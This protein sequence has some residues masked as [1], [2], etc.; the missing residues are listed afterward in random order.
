MSNNVPATQDGAPKHKDRMDA[1]IQAVQS[2]SDQLVILLDQSGITFERFVEVFRRALINDPSLV[3]ADAASVVQACINACTDGLLPDKRQ[4]AIV[5]YNVNVAE[6][7]KPKRYIKQAQWQPMYQGLLDLAYRSGLYRSIE[8]RVVYEGDHFEYELGDQPFIKHRPKPRPAGVKAPA[9]VAS[10]AVAVLTNGGV[11]REVFEGADIAKVNA[12]SRAASGPG[13][14]WPEEMA[15]KGPLRRMWKFIPK[16]AAM[17]RVVERDVDLPDA[18]PFEAEEP[19]P[20][21][22]KTGF[23]AISQGAD[24]VM[25]DAEIE[26]DAEI[27]DTED[28]ED[29]EP[30]EQEQQMRADVVNPPKDEGPKEPEAL[31]SFKIQLAKAETWRQARSA[32]QAYAATD[33]GEIPYQAAQGAAWRRMEALA[34]AGDKT[35]FVTDPLLFLCWVRGADHTQPGG[36]DALRGNL[37][38]I[39]KERTF[40]KLPPDHQELIRGAVEDMIQALEGDDD[41]H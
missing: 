13:V 11:F 18:D 21:T 39:E 16:S 27:V 2:R 24:P 4:G 23:A 19:A 7:G 6:K 17:A 31:R 37:A 25:P 10:Y 41:G 36:I 32:L 15:R 35:D 28:A 14:N 12:V 22:L 29:S 3:A 20:K 33:P 8:A 1:L 9:I 26:P 38:V 5:V 34:A 40:N 30:E